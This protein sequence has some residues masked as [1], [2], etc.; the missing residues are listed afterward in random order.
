MFATSLLTVTSHTLIC[1]SHA[2]EHS[3][4]GRCLPS[5]AK[6]HTHPCKI[7]IISSNLILCGTWCIFQ[8][9]N[10][11]Q[12]VFSILCVQS[13]LSLWMISCS[14]HWPHPPRPLTSVSR[15]TQQSPLI[16]QLWWHWLHA[17]WGA[18]GEHSPDL[19]LPLQLLQK[20]Y[21]QCESEH[22]TSC[23][24]FESTLIP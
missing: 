1:W 12:K 18:W 4:W 6:D 14:A 11:L 23:H 13:V 15:G 21:S 22:E 8:V 3:N 5:E 20:N 9:T 24:E 17:G 7:I 2:P 16:L 19:P 10:N